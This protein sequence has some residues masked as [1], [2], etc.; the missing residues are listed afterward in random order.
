MR[1]LI[2]VLV[3]LL[4]SCTSV[5]FERDTRL[6]SKTYCS[7][8]VGLSDEGKQYR[9]KLLTIPVDLSCV[10]RTFCSSVHGGVTTESQPYWQAPHVPNAGRIAEASGLPE[11]QVKK[12]LRVHPGISKCPIRFEDPEPVRIA[13]NDAEQS[14]SLI[15]YKI[16][17]YD[18]SN[19][20]EMVMYLGPLQDVA[21]AEQQHMANTL[22]KLCANTPGCLENPHM[23][24]VPP[25]DNHRPAQHP[26]YFVEVVL[27]HP[28]ID[29]HSKFAFYG[30]PDVPGLLVR[31]QDN[32]PGGRVVLL[33][34][35]PEKVG[36]FFTPLDMH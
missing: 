4:A 23:F 22:A 33:H 19:N 32:Y 5:D 36:D 31:F 11:D 1:Y 25:P 2:F 26:D 34:K 12:V 29:R 17:G 18:E 14:N 15:Q 35:R 6:V 30:Q 10:G 3:F 7:D 8:P 21:L 20:P 9:P 16:T 24:L 28:A 27:S 13:D